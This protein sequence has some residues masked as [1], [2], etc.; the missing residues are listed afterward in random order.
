MTTD[1]LNELCGLIDLQNKNLGK[2]ENSK[3]NFLNYDGYKESIQRLIEDTANYLKKY[4][5]LEKKVQDLKN[6]LSNATKA[7]DDISQKFKAAQDKIGLLTTEKLG[8]ENELKKLK[9]DEAVLED[10]PIKQTRKR[11]VKKSE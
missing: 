8:L 3:I 2:Y 5:E 7:F 10:K 11:G 6:S 9:S 1:E 4:K